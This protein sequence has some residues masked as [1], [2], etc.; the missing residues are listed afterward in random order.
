[1]REK[2]RLE[3]THET[4]AGLSTRKVA[5]MT[6]GRF[7][8]FL[9]L[10]PPASRSTSA[11]LCILGAAPYEAAPFPDGP[12]PKRTFERK[13]CPLGAVGSD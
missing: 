10:E 1:M 7:A 12:E 5:L 9:L 2:G 6:I 3:T 13:L 8:D 4:G 11:T